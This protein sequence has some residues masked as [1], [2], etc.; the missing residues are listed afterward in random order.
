MDYGQLAYLKAQTLEAYLN[1]TAA[2]V[3][4]TGCQSAAFYPHLAAES[5]Y[6]PVTVYGS[7]SVGLTVTLTLRAVSAV[8]GAKMRLYAGDK[9]AAYCSVSLETGETERSVLLASVYP[10]EGEVLRVV[11]DTAGLLI[12]EMFVLGEGAKVRLV[13][14][15]AFA[16]CDGQNGEVFVAYLRDGDIC[17]RKCG[18]DREAAAFKGGVFDLAVYCG[19]VYLI[20][21]DDIGNFMGLTYDFALNETSRTVL[22]R[23]A[24]DGVAIGQ[25]GGDLLIAGLKA[26][27]LSFC[28]ALARYKGLTAFEPADF[29]TEADAVHLSKQS[30]NSALF[31]QRGEGLYCKLPLPRR[32][33][34]DCIRVTFGCGSLS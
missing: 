6:A 34:R 18:T 3:Q 26:R 7:G 24:F 25:T 31:L 8:R 27:K 16:R 2:S 9:L 22:G 5:G 1:K 12:E 28:T 32:D 20:G 19:E 17:V 29:A 13:S 11:C 4:K 15:F 33:L 10:S 23:Y 21:C 30:A 14:R